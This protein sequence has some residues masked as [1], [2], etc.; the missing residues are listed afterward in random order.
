[1]DAFNNSK[2]ILVSGNR[3]GAS[4]RYPELT[5][6]ALLCK[7]AAIVTLDRHTEKPWRQHG[8]HMHKHRIAQ[9]AAKTAV[10]QSRAEGCVFQPIL[11]DHGTVL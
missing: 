2:N 9:Q 4:E 1:M 5:P 7:S 3:T 6:A 10:A 11:S 8:H